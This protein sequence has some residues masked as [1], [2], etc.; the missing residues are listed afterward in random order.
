MIVNFSSY[1]LNPALFGS[2]VLCYHNFVPLLR[3]LFHPCEI[4]LGGVSP[5]FL[6]DGP[7]YKA[8]RIGFWGHKVKAPMGTGYSKTDRMICV[9]FCLVENWYFTTGASVLPWT[10]Y[11]SNLQSPNV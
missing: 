5:Y 7:Q 3:V 4:D 6:S 2:R 11:T 1:T 9:K 10:H 8:V